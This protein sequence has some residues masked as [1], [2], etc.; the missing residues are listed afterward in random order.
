[1]PPKARVEATGSNPSYPLDDVRSLGVH[2]A[3]PGDSWAAK[4]KGGR[5]PIEEHTC[6]EHKGEPGA[7]SCHAIPAGGPP[8]EGE[9]FGNVEDDGAS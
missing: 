5:S 9:A 3:A 4:T 2:K 6:W 7:T 1:M 8:S